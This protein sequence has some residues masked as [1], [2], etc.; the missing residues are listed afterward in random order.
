MVMR[1]KA[2]TR[3][4]IM[5]KIEENDSEYV[6]LDSVDITRSDCD[7]CNRGVREGLRDNWRWYLCHSCA[8]GLG[9]IW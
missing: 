2:S 3:Q 8:Q 7:I 1:L 6:L 5:K 4:R 9:L